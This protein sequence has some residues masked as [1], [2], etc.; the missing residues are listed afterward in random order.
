LSV[1]ANKYLAPDVSD[2]YLNTNREVQNNGG[3][4][5]T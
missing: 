3:E 1:K 4:Y 2:E 5:Y